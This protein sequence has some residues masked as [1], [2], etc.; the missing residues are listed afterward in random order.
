MNAPSIG[1]FS[2]APRRWWSRLTLVIGVVVL[3]SLP[4]A[5]NG[6]QFGAKANAAR[7][8]ANKLADEGKYKEAVETLKSAA[9]LDPANGPLQQMLRDLENEKEQRDEVKSLQNEG[10]IDEAIKV[11]KAALQ[12]KSRRN[13]N[14]PQSIEDTRWLTDLNNLKVGSPQGA[15]KTGTG[16]SSSPDQLADE[17]DYQGAVEALKKV[18]MQLAHQ[19]PSD[20][21]NESFP[22]APETRSALKAAKTPRSRKSLGLLTPTQ[23]IER[24]VQS[25]AGV[26]QSGHERVT[27]WRDR[28]D[29]TVTG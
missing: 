12:T 7:E 14:K 22:F 3:C 10:K 20:G 13:G 19:I 23:T 25:V 4:F 21:A 26:F 28:L 17:G 1:G 29:A 11:A 8:K 6:Q 24:I 18:L 2:P 5:V 16:G 15:A 9:M 27:R